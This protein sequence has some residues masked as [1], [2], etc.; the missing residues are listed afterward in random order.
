[1]AA[2]TAVGR[3][4]PCSAPHPAEVV[5]RPPS[6]AGRQNGRFQRSEQ[7]GF[8]VLVAAWGIPRLP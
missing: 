7:V 5:L 2:A 6:L 8:G 4:A 3:R 1:M